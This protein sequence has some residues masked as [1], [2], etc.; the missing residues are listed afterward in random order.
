MIQFHLSIHIYIYREIALCGLAIFLCEE[1][2]HQRAESPIRPFIQFIVGDLQVKSFFIY[3]LILIFIFQNADWTIFAAD[4]LR[5]LACYAPLFLGHRDNQSG[6][7]YTVIID[8]LIKSLRANIPRDVGALMRNNVRIIKSLIFAILDWILHVP[9]EYLQQIQ[10]YQDENRQ[11]ISST[12][13]QRVFAVLIEV[14]NKTHSSNDEQKVQ[15]NELTL[16]QSIKLCCKFAILFLLN[17]HSHFPLTKNESS[18]IT[19]NVHEGHDWP[20]GSKQGNGNT[21]EHSTLPAVTSDELIIYSPNI[22]LFVIHDDFLISF[23]EIPNE[24]NNELVADHQ[25]FVSRTTLCRT[26]IRDLCGRYCWDNYAFNISSNSKAISKPF[27]NPIGN[28][29]F[30]ILTIR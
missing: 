29:S 17:E 12:I 28:E 16:S 20:N 18:L 3:S 11:D 5:F 25:H 2:K 15:D 10:T 8:G 6:Q 27:N 13:I 21:D 19:T 4:M 22:Q 23:I 9:S 14:Y 26:I 1:L 30:S 7:M 24:N